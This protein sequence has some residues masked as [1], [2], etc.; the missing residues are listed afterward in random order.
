MDRSHFQVVAIKKEG[1]KTVLRLGYDGYRGT[2]YD[3]PF[4]ADNKS[5]T[6]EFQCMMCANCMLKPLIKDDNFW[7]NSREHMH[8]HLS[9]F[10]SI[11][12]RDLK[13]YTYG[14]KMETDHIHYFIRSQ[15]A[16]CAYRP[17]KSEFQV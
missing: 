1:A 6:W 8:K 5:V 12:D 16:Y 3:H 10:H 7:T 13:D 15:P 14:K 2:V 17:K 11:S 4:E 9:E